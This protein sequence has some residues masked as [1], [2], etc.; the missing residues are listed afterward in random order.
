MKNSLI[1]F[2]VPTRLRALILSA[3]AK[4]GVETTLYDIEHVIQHTLLRLILRHV[5]PAHGEFP[6]SRPVQAMVE[7]LLDCQRRYYAETSPDRSDVNLAQ[8]STHLETA[9][10]A[11]EL[12]PSATMCV[13]FM[14]NGSDR[15]REARINFLLRVHAAG[16]CL[17]DLAPF[18]GRTLFM[19]AV[20]RQVWPDLDVRKASHRN[21]ISD[22]VWESAKTITDS[23]FDMQMQEIELGWA[24]TKRATWLLAYG[25][26]RYILMQD[27]IGVLSVYAAALAKAL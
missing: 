25:V 27:S 11:D 12:D 6:I 4:G 24:Y 9:I 14:A 13:L 2:E 10:L 20:L 16:V 26:R 23:L 7:S 21:H 18:D 15:S 1:D 17:I 22:A 5:S 3:M 19:D 8:A